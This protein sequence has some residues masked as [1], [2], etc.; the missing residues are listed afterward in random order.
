MTEDYRA[1]IKRIRRSRAVQNGLIAALLLG[2]AALGVAVVILFIRNDDKQDL[3]QKQDAAI[4]QLTSELSDVCRTARPGQVLPSTVQEACDRAKKGEKPDVLKG[5][6]GEPGIPG[7]R[8]PQGER[9]DVGQEGDTGA[10]GVPGTPGIPGERGERGDTG[11]QGAQGNQGPQGETGAQGIPGV[12]G[13]PGQQGPQGPPGP[14]GPQCPENYSPQEVVLLTSNG[15]T[16]ASVC[17]KNQE[18]P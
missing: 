3:N 6:R 8:G 7:E 10:Q 15:P 11:E 9:G 12:Q 14:T 17:V 1:E 16:E 18:S 2:V 5:E 4:N 13:E